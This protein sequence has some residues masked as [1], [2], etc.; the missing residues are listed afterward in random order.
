MEFVDS[1]EDPLIL[2]QTVRRHKHNT[3]STTPQIA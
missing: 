3:N 2:E 1:K